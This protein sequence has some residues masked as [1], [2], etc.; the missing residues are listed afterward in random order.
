MLMSVTANSIYILSTTVYPVNLP[1]FANKYIGSLFKA[2]VQ[3][4]YNCLY[5]PVLRRYTRNLCVT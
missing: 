1:N 4:N 2:E 3:I 5:V